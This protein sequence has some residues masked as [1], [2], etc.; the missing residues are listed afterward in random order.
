MKSKIIAVIP[1]RSDSNRLPNKHLRKING[2]PMIYYLIN[3]LYNV[4]FIDK[5]IVATSERSCDNKLAKISTY[6]NADVFRGTLDDVIGRFNGIVNE[7]N[8][9]IIIKANGDNPLLSFEVINLGISQIV[10]RKLDMVT[11]K[12]SYTGLPVGLGAEILTKNAIKWLYNNTP[13][14]MREHTTKYAFNKNSILKLEPIQIPKK[15]IKKNKSITIDTLDEFKK[16]NELIGNL[17][18]SEPKLWSINKILKLL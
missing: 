18:K 3:R 8:P 16:L 9:D 2:Y 6:Y 5:V 11:G 7:Y 12:N 10:N 15:W 13:T 4:N 14:E 1:A 17:P